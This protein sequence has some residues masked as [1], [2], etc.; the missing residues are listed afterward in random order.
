MATEATRDS[1]ELR[2]E[3]LKDGH[4][5]TVTIRLA[6]DDLTIEIGPDRNA[7][8]RVFTCSMDQWQALRYAAEWYFDALD[9][10]QSSA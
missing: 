7:P 8:K 2:F 6:G 4:T 1:T 9:E 10:A 3:R 5:I